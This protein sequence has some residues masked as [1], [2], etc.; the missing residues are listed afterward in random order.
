MN[1]LI[2]YQHQVS[3]DEK[4]TWHCLTKVFVHINCFLSIT[5]TGI[6]CTLPSCRLRPEC[7]QNSQ[8]IHTLTVPVLG[9]TACDSQSTHQQIKVFSTRQTFLLL[10]PNTQN[11]QTV[12]WLR[13]LTQY[14]ITYSPKENKIH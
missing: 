12:L 8:M 13:Q 10:L 14:R 1:A 3:H 11:S 6:N 2:P 5:T 7:D 4:Q 9:N